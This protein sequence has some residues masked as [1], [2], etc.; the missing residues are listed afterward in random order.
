MKEITHGTYELNGV[1]YDAMRSIPKQAGIYSI[2][3]V[4]ENGHNECICR[5]VGYSDNC[6]RAIKNHFSIDEPNFRLRYFMLSN[7]RKMIRI[8]FLK[9]SDPG[10]IDE[11]KNHWIELFEPNCN[12]EPAF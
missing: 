6:Q 5:Y 1:F 2:F 4:P 12:L 11:I 7:K 9:E 10:K 3:E 8:F